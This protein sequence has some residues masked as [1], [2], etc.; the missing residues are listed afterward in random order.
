MGVHISGISINADCLFTG[1]I[2]HTRSF[3]LREDLLFAK[4]TLVK[5]NHQ[6]PT[7]V[8]KQT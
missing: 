1:L 8:H 7:Q 4:G 2:S 5:I 3:I 6:M